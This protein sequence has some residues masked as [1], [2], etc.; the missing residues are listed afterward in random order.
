MNTNE[1]RNTTG[2]A[3]GPMDSSA[4]RVADLSGSAIAAIWRGQ[5]QLRH[6]VLTAN[7]SGTSFRNINGSAF[8]GAGIARTPQA[9]TGG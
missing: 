9:A 2:E 3:V 4:D 7:S 5:R 6:R 8:R 1:V